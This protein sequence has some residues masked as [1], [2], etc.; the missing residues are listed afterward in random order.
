[1]RRWRWRCTGPGQRSWQALRAVRGVGDEQTEH[2]GDNVLARH[3]PAG[4]G[5]PVSVVGKAQAASQLRSALAGRKGIVAVAPPKVRGGLAFVQGTLSGQPDNKAAYVTIGRVRTA[6]HAV[7]GADAKVGGGTAISMDVERYATRDRNVI[8]PLVLLVV[9]VILGLLLRS[10]VAP[11]VLI[12]TVVLS[13]G[14]ALGLSALAFRY[15]FG[16]AGTRHGALTGLAAT[17]A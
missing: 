3:F 1:M 8:I 16:F 17:A 5:D 7:P 15:L 13:F 11:L 6:E 2:P 10:V 9:L 14:A 4:A 12:G